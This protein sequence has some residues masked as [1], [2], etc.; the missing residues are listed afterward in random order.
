MT[1]PNDNQ[2]SNYPSGFNNGITIRNVPVLNTHSGKVFWVTSNGGSDINAGTRT[3]PR[4][5]I[6]GALALCKADRGDIIFCKSGHVET[7]TAAAQ[8]AIATSGVAIIGLG[9]GADRPTLTF[10]TSTAASVT[11]TANN[12]TIQNIVGVTGI[13]ALTNPFNVTGND[14]YLDIEWQDPTT[15]LEALRAVLATSVSRLS[16][17]IKYKGQTGGSSNLN[18][19]ALNGVTG[20]RINID[21]VGILTAGVVQFKTTAC[22]DVVVNGYM[23]VSGT[24]NGSL[25]VV[26]TI[27]GSTWYGNVSDGSAGAT[28]GGGS[29]L[30]WGIVDD[31]SDAVP[32]ANSTANAYAAQVLGNKT[33]NATK[34]VS[35]TASIVAY[36]KGL[37]NAQEQFAV[38]SQV[39]V[40]T[41]GM[42]L[43]TVAGGPIMVTGLVSI[44][45]TANN[46]TASTLQYEAISTLGTLTGTISGASATL[47]SAVIGTVVAL[48]G[49][50]LSTAPVIGATGVQLLSA[51]SI[52]V[53]AG[54]INAV[55]G[56]GSTTGTWTHYLRYQPMAAGVTVV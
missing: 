53:Q 36:E 51:V 4:A 6:M 46:A 47:A 41:N 38:S 10:T 29:A 9:Q 33:D 40:M 56:T 28:Y 43:F 26:D 7:I 52:V 19:I 13:N 54:T 20:A 17:K 50:A 44:C 23:Y 2:E 27:T 15:I 18:A 14:C 35:N 45:L 55:I 16:A 5:T 42:T 48:Q 30:A 49:I 25:D 39:G 32:A 1:K 31:S 12:V 24:T 8:I 37:V 11:I 21:Y 3:R 22:K 34:A